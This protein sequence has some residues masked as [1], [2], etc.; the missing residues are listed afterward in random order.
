LALLAASLLAAVSACSDGGALPGSSRATGT[1]SS[2]PSSSSTGST[3]APLTTGS[4]VCAPPCTSSMCSNCQSDA[5]CNFMQMT[6]P[7]DPQGMGSLLAS[8]ICRSLSGTSYCVQPCCN[9]ND[10]MAAKV[11]GA[12]CK[13]A[14]PSCSAATPGASRGYCGF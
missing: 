7:Q 1:S 11:H 14:P 2:P 8:R 13:N 4:T 10:C 5:D 12:T 6:A 3:T 9:I